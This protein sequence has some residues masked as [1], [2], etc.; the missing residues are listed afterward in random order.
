MKSSTKIKP[1]VNAE[2]LDGSDP[3]HMLM[4]HKCKTFD[5][6]A[7]EGFLPHMLEKLES[8]ICKPLRHHLGS[9]PPAEFKASY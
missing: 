1:M 3:V 2:V 8:G 4:L 5:D 7:N 6:Y 9:I